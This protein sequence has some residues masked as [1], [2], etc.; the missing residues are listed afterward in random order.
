MR[1][2]LTA[3]A[4]ACAAAALC[5]QARADEVY[6]YAGTPTYTSPTPGVPARGT[7]VTLDITDAAVESGSFMLSGQ[8]PA[9]TLP[10]P[11]TYSG[12]AAGLI[13]FSANG[14]GPATQTSFTGPG[15]FDISFVFDA[16]GNITSDNISY[17]GQSDDARLSGDMALTSG[18]IGSDGPWCNSD[19][20][21][22]KCT[23]SGS[24]TRTGDPLPPAS[25][26]PEPASLALLGAGLI[27]LGLARRRRAA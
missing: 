26:V 19:A 18:A 27:G 13:S 22:G 15:D 16:A 25:P 17:A 14:F 6:S 11:P 3:L 7:T 5:G 20:S 9:G 21:T 23:V 2:G 12:D 4:L 8:S 10:F 24:W 1:L